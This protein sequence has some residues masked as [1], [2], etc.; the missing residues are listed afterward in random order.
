MS[1]T[2]FYDPS[3]VLV[4]LWN[5]DF[6]LQ[7]KATTKGQV[8]Q[9][10]I[11]NLVTIL[12]QYSDPHL[13]LAILHQI[14]DRQKTNAPPIRILGYTVHACVGPHILARVA[15]EIHVFFFH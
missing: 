7:S 14:L 15:T 11:Y 5:C 6:I 10:T 4:Q 13:P 1:I 3:L 12:Q 9:A 8:L 2:N